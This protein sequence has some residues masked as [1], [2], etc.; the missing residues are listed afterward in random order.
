MRDDQI[1]SD[2]EA[3]EVLAESMPALAHDTHSRQL[4][5]GLNRK[6]IDLTVRI[7]KQI[8]DELVNR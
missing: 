4:S 2:H 8:T 1:K 5:T 3:L 6:V 7:R